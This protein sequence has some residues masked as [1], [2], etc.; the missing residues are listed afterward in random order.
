[1]SKNDN[2]DLE[3]LLLEIDYSRF[4]DP[5]YP[6]SEFALTFINF[7]KV[8][9]NG[10]TENKSPLAHLEFADTLTSRNKWD[11]ILVCCHRGFSKSTLIMYLFFYCAIYGRLPN[12]GEVSYMLYVSDTIDNG[13][14]TM[15]VNINSLISSS[16]YLQSVLDLKRTKINEFE[17]TF[18]TTAGKEFVVRGFGTTTGIRGTRRNNKRPEICV[19]DDLLTDFNAKSPNILES[20][21][22]TIYDGILPALS[23]LRNKVIW[24]GTPFNKGDPLTLAIKSGAWKVLLFPVAEKF[25]CDRKEYI[26]AWE[27]RFTY[28]FVKHTFDAYRKEHKV[29]SFY[30]EY[31]LKITNDDDRLVRDCDILFYDDRNIII[32]NK[33][34]YNFFITTDF[35]VSEKQEADYSVI[36]VWCYKD[37]KWFWVDGILKRQNFG[38]TM[39][40]LFRLCKL[41][42]PMS[43]AIEVS[44]QQGGFIPMIQRRMISDNVYFT[45]ASDKRTQEVGI[46]PN[47]SKLERFNLVLHLFQNH[48]ILFPSDMED[49]AVMLEAVDELRYATISGFKSAHDDF[50]DT[51]SQL[52]FIY[53]FEMDS[54]ELEQKEIDKFDDSIYADYM[55]DLQE[56][57]E[58]PDKTNYDGYI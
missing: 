11:R 50:I 27:D 44:G 6:I 1:M 57:Y 36:S 13:V 7:I 17:W 25:P 42:K 14:K 34:D 9:N 12:F 40:D 46:R 54:D 48:R 29:N 47:K 3:Q 23:P 22:K 55:Q 49:D 19:L 2:K 28:D 16:V 8:V 39:D 4:R 24:T 33:E 35:A 51:I 32:N 26:G 38:K 52:Q 10:V 18:V 53:E 15:G 43:T 37:K 30:K 56:F 58:N 21:N 20:I 41:Y 31:M 45:L 5:N